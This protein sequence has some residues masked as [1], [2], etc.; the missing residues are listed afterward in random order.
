MAHKHFIAADYR[1]ALTGSPWREDSRTEA[2]YLLGGFPHGCDFDYLVSRK[3]ITKPE[4]FLHLTEY[5]LATCKHLTEKLP[6]KTLIY[7]DSI[8]LGKKAERFLRIPFVHGKHSTKK[9]FEILN[10]CDRLIVSRIFDEGI[11]VPDLKS[12][13]ELDF[14]GKSR[15]QESQRCGRLHHCITDGATYHIL[16]TKEEYEKYKG[17]L[18]ALYARGFSIKIQA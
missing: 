6:P 18:H 5:K 4:I 2:I 9:R 3:Y 17:R 1:I 7:C 13:I 11:D 15:R 12:A 14:M 16:M 8:E 10:K